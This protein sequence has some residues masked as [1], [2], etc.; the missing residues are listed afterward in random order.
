ML[1]E[2]REIDS[3]LTGSEDE[4]EGSSEN[5]RPY[6]G[7]EEFDNSVLRMARPLVAAAKANPIPGT[8]DTPTIT[9]RLTRLDPSPLDRKGYDERIQRTVE[10]LKVMGIDIQLGE[11][12]DAALSAYQQDKFANPRRLQPTSS[13]NLDLSILIALVSDLT[14]APVPTSPEEAEARFTLS[15]SYLEWKKTRLAAQ[16]PDQPAGGDNI[17]KVSRALSTQVMQE[18]VRAL[19]KEMRERL[20][21]A[22]AAQSLEFWTTPEAIERCKQIV[23]KIGGPHEKRRVE[24]MFPADNSLSIEQQEELFWQDSRY[25]RGYIPLFPIRIFPPAA[26][27]NDHNISGADPS[28]PSFFTALSRTCYNI[29]AQDVIPDPR[30]PSLQ[31]SSHL[32]NDSDPNVQEDDG[33]IPRATVTKANHRL[34]AHTVQTMLWGASRGWTVL[35]ANKASVKAILREM[36]TSGN[37]VWE[38]DSQDATAEADVQAAALWVVEPR[39]LAEGMR[40]DFGAS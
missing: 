37:A 9:M 23:N 35:T 7:E 20:A 18:T 32:P 3:Y 25:S 21:P 27:L 28:L 29:L 15:A 24:V 4:S 31:S 36:K 5:E 40:A 11:R 2:F 22:I 8:S 34:T 6:L 30:A 39:S 33:E 13:V 38:R 16:N 1:A 10:G 19:W 12:S 26:Q 17:V 14:H